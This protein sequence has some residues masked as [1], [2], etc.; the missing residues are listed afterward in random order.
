[1]KYQIEKVTMGQLRR[2]ETSNSAAMDL[3][4]AHAVT[5]TGE[6]IPPDEA[7]AALDAM[8]MIEFYSEWAE[9]N[10]AAL[11]NPNGRRS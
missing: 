5:A 7:L 1:M 2:A 8:D 11:P 3:L 6:P 9:F 4:A 10:R